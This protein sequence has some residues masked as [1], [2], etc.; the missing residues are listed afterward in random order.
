VVGEGVSGVEPGLFECCLDVGFDLV[1]D[2][3]V[4]LGDAVVAAVAES[5][6]LGDLGMPAAMGQVLWLWRSSWKVN[7]GRTGRSWTV[8]CGWSLLPSKA[9]L[10]MQVRQV[11][12]QRKLPVSLANTAGWS[13]L[14][15]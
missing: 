13:W 15:R 1:G 11:W 3:S 4:D 8:G 7:P 12:R 6:C 10:N 2:V 5:A 14:A 9:G